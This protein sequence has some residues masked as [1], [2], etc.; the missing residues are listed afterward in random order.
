MTGTQ[1]NMAAGIRQF[2]QASPRRVAVIDGDKT[3]T[4]GQLHERSSRFGGALLDRGVRPGEPFAVLSNN[5]AEFFEIAAGLAKAGIVGVPLNTKNSV[6]DNEYVLDHCRARGIVMEE[7]LQGNVEGLIDDLD[8][9]IS[10]SGESGEQYE[11]VLSSARSVDPSVGI[12]ERDPFCVTYTS[13]TTGRPKGVKLT[14]RGRVLTAYGVGLEYGLGPNASTVAVAP[15]YHGAGFAFAYAGPFLGGSTSVLRSWDPERFLRILERDRAN[16]VFLV[17]THAQQIRRF[18]EEPCR[19]FD[20]SSLHTLYF[21]AAA[22]P[23]ALKEW[24]VEAFPGAGIHELYGSTECSVVTNLGPQ[25]ALAKAGSVGHPWFMNEVRLTDDDGNEVGPGVPGELFARSPMLLGGYLHDDDATAAG[26]DN[27]GFFSVGDIAVRDEE[28]FISIV[29]RKKDVIIAGGVNIFP[30]E[31]EEVIA[32]FGSVEDVA[33]L[34]VPDED[35]GERIT[36][37]V[38]SRPGAS[39]DVDA[40]RTYV[41]ERVAKYKTPRE[42]Y[43]LDELPRNSSGKILKRQIR[44]SYIDNAS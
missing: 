13:G 4:F 23:V 1:L 18:T 39:L 17:P 40:L 20:L 32:H 19:L 2:G 14:H 11:S 28:G 43:V 22:L 15:M 38:V 34:G 5:R 27:D 31:I 10:I 37:F 42:W 9:V 6:S 33:V 29:D 30:R 26:Y 41:S 12:D 44:D 35:Y 16:S 25:F 8:V 3:L 7:D 36:A 21:N 24:V